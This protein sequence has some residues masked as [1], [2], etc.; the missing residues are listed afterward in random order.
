MTCRSRA[1][2]LSV[3]QRSERSR[4]SSAVRPVAAAAVDLG[5]RMIAGG[6]PGL[7]PGGLVERGVGFVV[8]AEMAAAQQAEVVERLAVV[9]IGVAPG[10]ALDGLRK[11]VFGERELAALQMPEAQRVVAARV[12]RVAAQRF[13][14]VERRAAGG[15][16]ILVE[17]QAGDEQLV[18]AGDVRRRGR[19]GGGGGTSPFARGAGL[20]GDDFPAVPIRDA[21]RAD[22]FP[23]TPRGQLDFSD[24]RFAGREVAR[25]G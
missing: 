13:A 6:R 11:C 18:G 4:C 7:V 3:L 23:R 8:A 2:R 9:R 25:G 22:R 10:E 21:Q 19:L 12:Q 14:P 15:V 24:E 17:V 1:R 5:Q 20:A 16:A